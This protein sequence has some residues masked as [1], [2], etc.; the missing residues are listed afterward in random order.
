M[1]MMMTSV[2]NQILVRSV[3][4]LTDLSGIINKSHVTYMDNAESGCFRVPASWP[5]Y[6]LL[7]P[8]SASVGLSSSSDSHHERI[9]Y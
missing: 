5:T 2:G 7:I 6:Q 8:T 4:L 3:S 1:M 9:G